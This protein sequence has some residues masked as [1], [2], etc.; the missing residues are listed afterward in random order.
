[1]ESAL[2][3]VPAFVSPLACSTDLE[4]MM[5]S[6]SLLTLTLVTLFWLSASAF[7][8]TKP[9]CSVTAGALAMGE[10][11]EEEKGGLFKALGDFW[12]ELDNF[13]DDAS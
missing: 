9:L 11:S 10:D 5:N 1:M 12:Q 3:P 7:V 8:P 6:C 2:W 13:M 4:I